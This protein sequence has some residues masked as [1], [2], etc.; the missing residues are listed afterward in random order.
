VRKLEVVDLGRQC[1]DAGC[2]LTHGCGQLGLPM[3]ANIAV[4]LDCGLTSWATWIFFF[5]FDVWF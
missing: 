3:V 1:E 4:W 5:L 2:G